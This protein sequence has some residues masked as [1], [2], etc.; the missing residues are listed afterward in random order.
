MELDTTPIRRK[1][2]VA[3]TVTSVSGLKSI[4]VEVA[5]KFEHPKFHKYITRVSK[6]MAH[7]E[8][9]KCAVGDAVTIEESRPL[10]ARKRWRVVSGSKAED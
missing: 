7:D 3:G 6:Y 9:C 5:R 2:Q 8:H 4:V 10:S 1:R